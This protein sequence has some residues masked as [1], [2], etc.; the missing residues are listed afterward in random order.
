LGKADNQWY[1][2]NHP[3]TANE[4][5]SLKTTE[6]NRRRYAAMS[7]EEKEAYCIRQSEINQ[8]PEYKA[9]MSDSIKGWHQQMTPEEKET[10]RLAVK[11]GQANMSIEAKKAHSLKVSAGNKRSHKISIGEYYVRP[12]RYLNHNPAKEWR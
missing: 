5:I 12:D 7:E 8:R 1:H 9:K 10:W 11:E 3:E 2:L 6:A 4:K